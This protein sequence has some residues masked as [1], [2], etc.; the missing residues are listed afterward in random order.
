MRMS[1]AGGTC[2]GTSD[3]TGGD[4]RVQPVTASSAIKRA[5]RAN[6]TQF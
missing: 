5:E 4:G 6:V 3:M 2:T 1:A